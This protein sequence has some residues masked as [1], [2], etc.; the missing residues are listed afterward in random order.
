[1]PNAETA[2]RRGRS[3]RGQGRAVASS[4]TA[5]ASQSMCDEGVPACRVRGS[6]PAR[7]ASTI[8]NTLATPAADW[9]CPML[10]FTE[11]SQSGR[12][13]SRSRP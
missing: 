3:P 1:M 5:P 6:R 9:V 10:D 11:P 8:F 13:A 2:Q 4:S 12:S 7:S